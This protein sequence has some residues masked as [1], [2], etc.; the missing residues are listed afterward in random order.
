MSAAATVENKRDETL[1]TLSLLRDLSVSGAMSGNTLYVQGGSV[2][3]GDLT[4]NGTITS[5]TTSTAVG[6]VIRLAIP[7]LPAVPSDAYANGGG[8]C[9]VGTTKK[10][11]FWYNAND[12]WLFNQ[13]INL[14]V[15]ISVTDPEDNGIAGTDY[16]INGISVLNAT[17]LGTGI[18]T[19][20]LE[21]VAVLRVGSINTT[22]V[23]VGIA[24]G[25]TTTFTTA[26]PHGMINGNYVN[27]TS[28]NCTPAVTGFYTIT[29]VT[30]FAFLVA[31]VTVLPGTAGTYTA[32]GFPISVGSSPIECGNVTT[33]NN[34]YIS[35]LSS[36]GFEKVRIDSAPGA[37]TVNT[38]VTDALFVTNSIL[39]N[40]VGNIQSARFLYTFNSTNAA[41]VSTNVC[42]DTVYSGAYV[43]YVD[44][45]NSL[46]NASITI[47]STVSNA[48]SQ[49]TCV[50]VSAVEVSN[51]AGANIAGLLE[52]DFA[53]KL[54]VSLMGIAGA[55]YLA[56]TN[57]GVLGAVSVSKA[58]LATYI[59]TNW[60][61][62]ANIRA[63]M[64]CYNPNVVPGVDY[65]MLAIGN[66][67]IRG[68]LTITG[69]L[70]FGS[71]VIASD[72]TPDV[73]NL[74]DISTALLR[75]RDL[76]LSRDVLAAGVVNSAGLLP[77][78]PSV[79]DV[80][81]VGYPW[82]DIRYTGTLYGG[83]VNVTSVTATTVS[84]THIRPTV[85]ATYDLGSLAL[86]WRDFFI[87]G[88]INCGNLTPNTTGLSDLGTALLKFKDLYLSGTVR[89]AGLL[90][91]VT[92]TTDIG[93][94][95]L[96][97][98]DIYASGTVS[99]GNV[100]PTA[101]STYSLGTVGLP[102]NQGFFSGSVNTG[103]LIP[104]SDN[105]SDIGITGTQRYKNAFLSGTLT[106]TGLL[107]EVTA[108]TDVGAALTRYKDLWLSGTSYSAAVVV[109]GNP[110]MTP[111]VT[112]TSDIGTSLLK[113][114]DAY[115]SGN[116]NLGGIRPNVTATTDI[117]TSL[118]KFKDIYFTGSLI[119]GTVTA[120]TTVETINASGGA[121][122]L[123]T[124]TSNSVS[125]INLTVTST[126]T[127]PA[128]TFP[129]S[130]KIICIIA[131]PGAPTTFTVTPNLM[132]NGTTIQFDTVGQS[133]HLFYSSVGKWCQADGGAT[134]T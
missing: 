88:T 60:T 117:G 89:L 68:D 75:F 130:V 50:A 63:G 26:T 106:S 128:A 8:V 61:P 10:T 111:T 42:V 122:V 82:N 69:G 116:V 132:V 4:V 129:G 14:G 51:H 96:R 35:M 83:A 104:N 81:S 120:T 108:T 102:W 59:Q 53:E 77:N 30:D 18:T 80:G 65:A 133:I 100:N 71:F 103:A 118:L 27:I 15:G 114:K 5:S 57:V 54:N 31:V 73:D 3:N 66:S 56:A 16:M 121:Y 36:A 119:G 131:A 62:P 115:L 86:Y 6:P 67:E 19:S 87:S 70:T 21:R 134:I 38:S 99:S 7:A 45:V 13:N 94:G 25:L 37:I 112:G 78:A 33:T 2:M 1:T 124:T 74:R 55:S 107:P 101:A 23:I 123:D 29:Y 97:F 64:L 95:A 98:K 85:T 92:A 72:L 93:S 109:S 47:S 127:L 22:G 44:F 12:S 43:G 11:M 105:A 113:F 52:T 126:A 125:E 17:R 110:G 39:G 9:L 84:A 32:G 76:R 46:V 91:N 49:T 28:S 24:N 90:P 58:G 40:P 48:L 79:Y 20:S 41:T 34:A